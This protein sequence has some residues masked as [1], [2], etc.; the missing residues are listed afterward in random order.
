M[1]GSFFYY[2]VMKK[3][4]NKIDKAFI[5]EQISQIKIFSKYLNISEDV[6]N[7]CIN[8][9]KLIKSPLRSDS[10]PSVGFQYNNRNI[11]K[12]RDFG[13]FFWGDCFDIVAYVLT[14]KHKTTVN[15]NNKEHFKYILNR[16]ANEFGVADGVPVI[17]DYTNVLSIIKKA[18]RIINFEPRQWN[19]NDTRYWLTRYNGLF[20]TEYLTA[21]FVFPVERFWI[22]Y[23][24]QPEP[25]YYY[26]AKDP[27]YAYYLGEDSDGISNIRLYFPRRS[28]KDNRRPKFI[29]NNSSFQGILGI[30]KDYDYIILCK[31][32]KD[33][34]AMRRL[35]DLSFLKGKAKVL[36]IAYPSENYI[37]TTE[38]VA[39][40]LSLLKYPSIEYIIN[41]IDFDRAGR[42]SAKATNDKFG[43]RYVFLTNGELGLPS[44][45]AKD[46]TDFVAKHGVKQAV[47]LIEFYI[48]Y[49]IL[50]GRETEEVG[51]T[52]YF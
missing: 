27:C 3:I 12:M 5:L 52:E 43:I 25:K 7:N 24:S 29:G 40:L 47:S 13:G 28:S 44:N 9:G 20:T 41:F 1:L 39:Y 33:V 2:F 8:T 10:K 42:K 50:N 49:Y 4:V 16:L 18:K 48:K 36:F 17:E 35:F 6:I 38:F 46:I 30:D 15:V 26:T 45:N 21:N 37:V 32:Y 31:S 11:L 34:L 22:D 19:S 23:N 14:Y 51:E